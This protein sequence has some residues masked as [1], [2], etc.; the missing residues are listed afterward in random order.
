LAAMMGADSASGRQ[1]AQ[2][3]L[4]RAQAARK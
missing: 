3:L 1:S 4:A 2:E